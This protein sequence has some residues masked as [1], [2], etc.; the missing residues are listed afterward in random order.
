MQNAT[1]VKLITESISITR[2]IV[3]HS[4]YILLIRA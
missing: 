2:N 3:L 1:K 4:K